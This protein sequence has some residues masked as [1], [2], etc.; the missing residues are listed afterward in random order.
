MDTL[1]LSTNPGALYVLVTYGKRE[2]S[3][4]FSSIVTK[5]NR[6]N[7]EQN[8][9][10][11]I[12]TLALYNLKPNDFGV[13]KRRILIENVAAITISTSS[14][15]FVI[16][17]PDE[18]DYRFKS[19]FKDSIEKTLRKLYKDVTGKK[20]NVKTVEN[21]SL[22]NVTIT[23]DIAIHLSREELIRRKKE[24]LGVRRDSDFK[25]DKHDAA[26]TKQIT[27]GSEKLTIESFDL[28]KVLGRGAFGKVMQVRKKDTG[29][30]YAIK[31]L[32][33]TMVF[34]RKQVEHTLAERQVLEAFQH[35]FLMGLR[36]AFQTES[37]LY[38]VMDFYKGGELFFHLRQVK[39]FSEEQSRFFVAQIGLA[40]GHL[41]SLD[42]IYRDIKPEN[43][44]MD[45][46]GYICL[47]D[48]GLAKQLSQETAVTHSFVGTPEY[49]APEMLRGIGHNKS[50]D[51]WCLGIL[52]YELTVGVT[53]FY[54][55]NVDEL[56]HKIVKSSLKF[57]SKMSPECRDLISKLLVRDPKLRL[58]SSDKD[59]EEI[60]SHEFFKGFDWKKLES[61]RLKPPYIPKV[62]VAEDFTGNF[63]E[64]YLNEAPK[65]SVIPISHLKALPADASKEFQNWTF[66]VDDPL[67][68]KPSK[69]VKP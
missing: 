16:H 37:K 38:L 9:A 36:Y 7:K 29:K 26:S 22:F 49:L 50:V 41:H 27:E 1:G 40:L 60:K 12:T 35:P 63:S 62:D 10:L 46:T 47:T 57:P 3:V 19:K 44:L 13:C 5:V 51:W 65:D 56:Y 54:S 4:V 53:P 52:L 58:G 6:K 8:R 30:I 34:A 55:K 42:F 18:Y 23:K 59:F 17:V 66:K 31:I 68:T 69:N 21:H 67:Q 39:R 25:E 2:E 43:I 20:L 45:E 48:F 24:L 61:K 32:K 14:D 11:M 33:K 64:K 15:E 28:L